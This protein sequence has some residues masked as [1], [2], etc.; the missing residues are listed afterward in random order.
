MKQP[1]DARNTAARALTAPPQSR[2]PKG[3]MGGANHGGHAGS[4]LLPC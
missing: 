3:R 2:F 4:G 1:R